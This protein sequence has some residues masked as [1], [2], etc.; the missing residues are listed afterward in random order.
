V[1]AQS[2]GYQLNINL[3]VVIVLLALLLFGI[4]YAWLVRWLRNRKANHGYTA[5]LVAVGDLV[6]AAA[7]GILVGIDLAVLLLLCLAAAGLP[8]IFE[9]T[10]WYLS[11]EEK[12]GL[13]I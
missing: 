9:Y 7:F 10:Q 6:V 8:M 3:I 1:E 5:V 4:G 2:T 13:D 11:N 12:G